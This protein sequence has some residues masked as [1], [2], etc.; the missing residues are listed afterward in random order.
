MNYCIANIVDNAENTNAVERRVDRNF[1]TPFTIPF[2]VIASRFDDEAV[3]NME[4]GLWLL[5]IDKLLTDRNDRPYQIVSPIRKIADGTVDSLSDRKELYELLILMFGNKPVSNAD[6][7]GKLTYAGIIKA[8]V[9][10]AMN[11]TVEKCIEKATA[12]LA[13]GMSLDE[14][15]QYAQTNL[16]IDMDNAVLTPFGVF[17][18]GLTS[19]LNMVDQK[20]GATVMV[21]SENLQQC[22][23]KFPN[24][25]KV[26]ARGEILSV[27]LNMSKVT[28]VQIPH[29]AIAYVLE[30]IKRNKCCG[31][32]VSVDGD[33]YDVFAYTNAAEF[34]ALCSMAGIETIDGLYLPAKALDWS[35]I[36]RTPR[37]M[38]LNQST[39]VRFENGMRGFYP[40]NTLIR[41]YAGKCV[42]AAFSYCGDTLK[43]LR[44]LVEKTA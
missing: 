31:L 30:N 16:P 39:M 9:A 24:W 40:L 33:T 3:M 43:N 38:E 11:T 42:N 19:R 15:E 23:S 35:L 13:A 32:K 37:Q 8:R 27:G 28:D 25:L 22:K 6:E 10:H 12:E 44:I 36:G 14:L 2:S 7:N 20:S 29:S 34:N 18:I 5:S 41:K 4:R 1:G 17:D 21:T 26:S